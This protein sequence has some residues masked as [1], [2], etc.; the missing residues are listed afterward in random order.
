MKFFMISFLIGVQSFASIIEGDVFQLSISSELNIEKIRFTNKEFKKILTS[1]SLGVKND[2]F[3]IPIEVGTSP[4]EYPLH[5][6]NSLG[7]E[8]EMNS[9][10]LRII[11]APFRKEKLKVDPRHVVL[12][13]EN[14]QRAL[15]EK[16]KVNQIY[17]VVSDRLFANYFSAP[18]R[19][20]MTSRFGTKRIFN[21]ETKSV[22]QGIDFKSRIGDPIFSPAD[23]KVVLTEDQF[24]SGNCMI[25]DHGRGIYSIFAHLSNFQAKI[26]DLVK[27]NQVIARSGKSGRSSGPHLHWGVVIQGVKVNPTELVRLLGSVH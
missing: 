13:P 18:S 9:H 1:D 27:K 16:E 23:G 22:H 12:S 3:W 10:K 8:I 5:L 2:I 24:F 26:G 6:L 14:L 15:L 17:S 4:G 11:A 7:N 20:K 19:K 21:G 25:I